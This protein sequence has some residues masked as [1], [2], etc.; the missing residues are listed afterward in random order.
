MSESVNVVCQV[1]RVSLCSVCAN[2]D[3][4]RGRAVYGA[5]ELCEPEPWAPVSFLPCRSPLY[6]YIYIYIYI[7]MCIYIYIYTHT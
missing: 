2:K 7:Y 4:S 3:N 5:W 1:C 6:I